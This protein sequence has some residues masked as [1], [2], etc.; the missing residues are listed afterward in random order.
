MLRKMRR[1]F[2][3]LIV[4]LSVYSVF[5]QSKDFY[6]NYDCYTHVRN[7]NPASLDYNLELI[8]CIARHDNYDKAMRLLDSLILIYPDSGKLY[9]F[10]AICR[11]EQN[12]YDTT[13][14]SFYKKAIDLNYNLSLCYENMGGHYYNF[15]VFCEYKNSPFKLKLKEKLKLL[16]L[17]EEN[18]LKS[19][20]INKISKEYV[21]QDLALVKYKRDTLLGVKQK[22][23]SYPDK[24]DTITIITSLL[25]CGEFGGH[26]EYVKIYH[27]GK[28][29]VG[30]LSLDSIYCSPGMQLD[31]KLDLSFKF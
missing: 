5:G 7:E 26:L 14:I 11:L 20:N 30:V 24:F 17:A 8:Q 22:E 27:S 10:K 1:S 16:D 21:L 4:Y 29:I 6:K 25:D 13:C 23:L 3:L 9:F 28:D 2:I 19:I 12:M 18:Y 31:A 15:L